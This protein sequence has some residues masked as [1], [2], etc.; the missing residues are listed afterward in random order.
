M[1][2]IV[3]WPT[4]NRSH[5]DA[6]IPCGSPA[7]GLPGNTFLMSSLQNPLKEF[8]FRQT[9]G[10]SGDIKDMRDTVALKHVGH[11]PCTGYFWHVIIPFNV[12]QGSGIES[13]CS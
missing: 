11:H 7:P 6:R 8:S 4:A 13:L 10:D 5:A 12:V 1:I 2:W 9:R 3:W